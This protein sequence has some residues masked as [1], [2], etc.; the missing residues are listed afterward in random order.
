MTPKQRTANATAKRIANQAQ[1]R[2]AKWA[3]E[4]RAWGWK[5]EAPAE[6]TVPT[7]E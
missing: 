1:R 7:A 5:L 3:K 2:H 6:Y 4:M